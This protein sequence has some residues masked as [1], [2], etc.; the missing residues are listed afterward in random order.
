[1]AKKAGKWELNRKQYQII[2]KMDH[3]EME[4][5]MNAVY[6]NGI[7]AGRQQAEKFD[8]LL[9]VSEIYKMKGIGAMKTEAIYRVLLAAGAQDLNER[10]NEISEEL[11]ALAQG[12]KI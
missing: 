9:A 5:Y 8:T 10:V 12:I 6:E 7:N 4:A 3:Q 11:R 2:R 1:M